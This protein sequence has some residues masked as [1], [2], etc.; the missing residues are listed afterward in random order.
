MC[1]KFFH[2]LIKKLQVFLSEDFFPSAGFSCIEKS[3][4]T[5]DEVAGGQW[6][7]LGTIGSHLGKAGSLR[8][9]L[10]CLPVDIDPDEVR[11]SLHFAD[12]V[13]LKISVVKEQE[14]IFCTMKNYIKNV[15]IP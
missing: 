10:D 8:Q 13:T 15:N 6:N 3:V 5:I 4:C 7:K 2:L 9:L 12:E 14:V 1:G 11:N